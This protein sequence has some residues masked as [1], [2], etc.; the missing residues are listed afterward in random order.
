MGTGVFESLDEV[1]ALGSVIYSAIDIAVIA[2]DEQ[3]K[4]I[5]VDS[6]ARGSEADRGTAPYTNDVWI[7]AY[8]FTASCDVY[9]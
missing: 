7:E 5:H 2:V 4:G 1:E 9:S 6:V 8:V 3:S